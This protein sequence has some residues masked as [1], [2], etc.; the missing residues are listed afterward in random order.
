MINQDPRL[1]GEQE[2]GPKQMNRRYFMRAL[3]ADQILPGRTCQRELIAE[4]AEALAGRGRPL[5]VYYNHSCN[6]AE[7][8][9]WE[10]AVG[11]HDPDKQKFARNLT[12]IVGW[13]GERYKDKIQA[14]WFDSPYLPA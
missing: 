6:Q 13:M 1:F 8:R 7:D 12:D 5:L 9:A 10:P 2:V 14:W 11:Y 4:L 3:A